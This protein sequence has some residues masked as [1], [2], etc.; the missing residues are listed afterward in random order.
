M[1]LFALAGLAVVCLTAAPA[2]AYYSCRATHTCASHSYYRSVDSHI[3]H[4]PDYNLHN[5]SAH[6]AD[7]TLSHSRHSR[8]T[9]SHH[10]GVE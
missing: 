9:C 5:V 10:G 4:G 6:C 2:D 1:K 8:G 7:G 3:V